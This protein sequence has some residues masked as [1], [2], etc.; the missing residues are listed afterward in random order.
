MSA[1]RHPEFQR[2]ER[3]EHSATGTLRGTI[4]IALTAQPDA[5]ALIFTLRSLRSLWLNYCG[6][7]SKEE[8]VESSPLTSSDLRSSRATSGSESRDGFVHCGRGG[9]TRGVVFERV[10]HLVEWLGPDRAVV[11]N[12]HQCL[13]ECRTVNHSG[14]RR[15]FTLVVALLLLG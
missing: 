7:G 14:R 3:K 8:R 12:S 13:Q 15:Q 2:K 10:E 4:P 5:T 6:R 11:A 9:G 1:A